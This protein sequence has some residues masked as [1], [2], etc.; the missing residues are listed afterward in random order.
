MIDLE[1]HMSQKNYQHMYTIN[2]PNII[3]NYLKRMLAEMRSPLLPL[4]YFNEF[5]D[6]EKLNEEQL[7]PR[8]RGVIK[9]LPE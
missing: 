7:I 3:A 9:K 6:L 2:D 4:R 5:T 8:I 1:I